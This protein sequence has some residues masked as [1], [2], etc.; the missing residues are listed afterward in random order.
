LWSITLL[1]ISIISLLAWY[2]TRGNNK[3][4]F[5]I[6]ALITGSAGLMFLVDKAY[7]YLEEGVFIETDANAVLLTIIL[8]LASIIIW[9]IILVY[10]AKLKQLNN[11]IE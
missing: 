4:R 10:N 1:A 2:K 3:Y 6:L 8:V 7:T 9:L 11:T 5:D